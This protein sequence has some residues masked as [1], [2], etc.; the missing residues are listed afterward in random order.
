MSP[1]MDSATGNRVEA[2][3]LNLL[4]AVS[5]GEKVSW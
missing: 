1:P 5:C 2:W 3:Q 4:K